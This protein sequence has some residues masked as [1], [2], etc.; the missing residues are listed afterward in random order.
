MTQVLFG[1]KVVR[2]LTFTVFPEAFPFSRVF[3]SKTI[4]WLVLEVEEPLA[5]EE[6]NE[7]MLGTHGASVR[8][9]PT[10]AKRVRNLRLEGFAGAAAGRGGAAGGAGGALLLVNL[11]DI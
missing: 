7:P 3:S 11:S 1:G 4:V 2:S 8:S 10:T 5:E 6:R 9:P